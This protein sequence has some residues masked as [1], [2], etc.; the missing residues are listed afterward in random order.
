MRFDVPT[1]G[2]GTLEMMAEVGGRVLVVESEKTIII[3]EQ[4]VIE[5]ANKHNIAIITK[6]DGEA[7]RISGAA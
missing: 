7:L 6:R 3:D 1:I 5:F 2:L 4:D